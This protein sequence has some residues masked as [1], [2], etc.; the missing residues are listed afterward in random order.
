MD[1]SDYMV[2]VNS[3][4]GEAAGGLINV[5]VRVTSSDEIS[6]VLEKLEEKGIESG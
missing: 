1:F 6:R 3:K 2:M 5:I 4:L